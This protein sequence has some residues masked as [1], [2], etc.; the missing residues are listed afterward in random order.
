MR[1]TAIALDYDGTIAHDGAVPPHVLDGLRRLKATGRKLLLVTGRELDELL[2]IFPEIGIFDRVVA[3]NGALLYRPE[4]GERKELGDPPP[5]EFLACLRANGMPLSVGHTIVATIRPHETFVLETIANLGL[6]HQVI[7]NKGAVMVLPPGCNKASGL[8]H[9][10]A[11]LGLS[12]RNVVAAGDGE[13]DH[14]LLDMAEYSAAVANAIPTLKE[15][16]D[17]VTENHHGD[18][19]LEIVEGLIE[20]DLARMP[21]RKPRRTLC[22]G[23][24]ES[25]ADV[26]LPRRRASIL[27]SGEPGNTHEFSIALLE[28]LCRRGYQ[29]CVLD[30]RGD[31]LQFKAAV[32]FGTLDNPPAVEE[33]LTALEKPTVQTVVCL[34]AVA[35]N[36]RRAF[37]ERLLVPLRKLREATGRPHWI[38]VDEATDLLAASAHADESATAAAENTIYVSCEPAALAPDILGSVHGVVACGHGAGAMIDAFAAAVSWGKPVLP[39]RAPHEHEALV[40]F[41]RSERPA[42]LI[43]I[44]RVKADAPA[45]SGA[46][47]KS[48]EV[49]Q[50]LRRA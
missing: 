39:A 6:E 15:A 25:G 37:V 30:T 29:V 7:F 35:G 49:G 41:R 22:L 50:V 10:L 4:T 43:D 9:A 18:G 27:V 3:E 8:R 44:E 2:G 19:V 17:R 48:E 34:A 24:D 12:P 31:Y 47:E 32:V 38:L 23:K 42:A 45:V 36:E 11:E 13:N 14:A 21:P 28:R 40:W 1:Y 33:V 5:E 20:H 46:R 26:V 16:A